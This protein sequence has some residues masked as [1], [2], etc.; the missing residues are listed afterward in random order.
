MSSF[1]ISYSRK[2]LPFAEKLRK[3]IQLLDSG[4][5]VFLDVYK[6]KTGAKWKDTLLANIRQ[7]DYFILVL[8][9]NAANSGYVQQ[10]IRWV[11]QD[12]LKT[13][14]RKLF[15]FRIDEVPIPP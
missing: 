8:S 7:N 2:D 13:G 5:D 4:H 3:H 10:E 14:I 15:V 11:Q 12:E 9:T 1:F 6:I